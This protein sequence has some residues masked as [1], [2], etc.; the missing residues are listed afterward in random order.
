M[1]W[2][3]LVCV[4]FILFEFVGLTSTQWIGLVYCV[5]LWFWW[6]YVIALAFGWGGW[7]YVAA[8]IGL[9]LWLV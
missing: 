9:W 2:V 5:A 4:I 6:D 7:V 1:G 8:F 3:W